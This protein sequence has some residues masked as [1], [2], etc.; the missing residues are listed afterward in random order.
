MIDNWKKYSSYMV[1]P[2]E[3]N[4]KTA[5]ILA[6]IAF[7]IAIVAT[8]VICSVVFTKKDD[9]EPTP[10]PTPSPVFA[11]DQTI[12]VAKNGND[13]TGDG[14]ISDP[15]L[16]ITKAMTT[17][18]D[19]TP[20]KRYAI[21]VFSGLY[22]EDFTIKPNVLII[23]SSRTTTRLNSNVAWSDSA[24]S[25]AGDNRSGFES[26]SILNA[27]NID[28]TLTNA[29][30]G[31]VFLRNINMNGRLTLT[32]Y[33]AINQAFL[34]ECLFFGGMTQNGFVSVLNSMTFLNGATV[35]LNSKI[36]NNTIILGNSGSCDGNLIA[37]WTTGHGNIAIQLLGCSLN[38][39]ITL[40]GAGV[41]L[42]S[43]ILP[44]SV[45]VLN[46]ATITP[47]DNALAIS[48]TPITPTNWAPFLP[49]TVQDALDDIVILN[50]T[51]P[52]ITW[53]GFSTP[54]TSTCT[55]WRK[56]SKI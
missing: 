12:Y 36:N 53:T 37:T 34:E 28:F 11:I 21:Q 30:E 10:T 14:S 17:I 40:D 31:K 52:T 20:A 23:G 42:S 35:Y 2:L 16:T 1:T 4:T 38:G 7:A 13:T 49:M 5:L 44:P 9:H 27:M 45:T 51:T 26:I 39:T 47:L 18:T 41:S 32:S 56:G 50:S 33:S 54:T 25:I 3:K 43:S 29:N 48:Y 6:G 19:A 24:W 55:Y 15:Y 46:G 8:I 22:V